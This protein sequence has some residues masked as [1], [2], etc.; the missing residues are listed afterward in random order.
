MIMFLCF[1]DES[2]DTGMAAG[3]SP[4]FILTA[5]VVHELRW[6]ST[7]NLL[8]E[9]RRELRNE[10]GLKVGEELHAQ[11]FLREPGTL[12][13]IPKSLRLRLLGEALTFASRLSDLADINVVVDKRT[14]PQDMDIFERAWTVLLQRFHN[15]VTGRSFPGSVN[16]DE[17]GM[18]IVDTTDEAALRRLVR[19]ARRF[20][21]VPSRKGGYREL[22]M[23]HLVEDP[24]HRDSQQSYFIQIADVISYFSSSDSSP[25]AT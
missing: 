1:V 22:P 3:G 18:V 19:R 13:K 14:K 15:G 4:F 9:F 25:T 12:T 23:E 16:D 2:G 8:L 7:L 5:V 6:L 11:V 10:Y 17:R 24:V 20:N 21:P